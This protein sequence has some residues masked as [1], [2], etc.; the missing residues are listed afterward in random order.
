MIS[1]M[2]LSVT[3]LS[4]VAGGGPATSKRP[5][6]TQLD[7]SH[8]WSVDRQELVRGDRV[9]EIR[10]DPAEVVRAVNTVLEGIAREGARLEPE[11]AGPQVRLL[12]IRAGTARCEVLNADYLTQQMGTTGAWY[13]LAAATFTLTEI[14]GVKAV[15]F[16]F[17]EGDHAGPG[18]YTRARFLGG[19]EELSIR[20]K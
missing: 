9:D 20:R 11:Q 10:K 16:L 14:P 8:V 6:A 5:I 15:E 19:G 18:V 3:L 17:E 4:L 12:G 1:S 13:W 7:R 2:T